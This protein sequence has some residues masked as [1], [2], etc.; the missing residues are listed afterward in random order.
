MTLAAAARGLVAELATHRASHDAHK[1]LDPAVVGL[2]RER[3]FLGCLVPHLLGG[4]ELPPA[5]Y[6]AVLEALAEGDAATGWVTMTASTSAML[7]AYLP[8]TTATALWGS[9]TPLV[10]GVFAPGGRIDDQGRLTGKWS[11]ASGS[12]HADWFA[13]GALHD[14][15]H[16]VCFV[17]RASVRVVDHWDTLGLAGTGSHDLEI[18]GVPLAPDHTCSLFEDAPWP[19]T[20]LYRVPVFGL[21]AVGIASCA[22]G[23]ARGALGHAAARLRGEKEAPSPQIAKY[24][25]LAAELA[26][27]RAYLLAACT[28]VFEHAEAR[29]VNG[30]ARGEL[31]LAAAHVTARCAEVVR[32]CFHVDGAAALRGR[33]P[34]Q[35]AL[36]DVEVVLTHKMVVD[37]VLPAAGRAL[38]GLGTP[39]PDL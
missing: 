9:G 4:A 10:A 5:D 20:A 7:G 8:C 6:V 15:R 12:R 23:I 2:L 30:A 1:Q 34:L 24:A 35:L 33:H 21:L 18:D 26:A 16:R 25:E 32:G 29:V 17:P 14:R 22:L 19:D 38:L 3:G 36:R 11:W 39:P 31:R 13:V 28:S 37:R 27:A